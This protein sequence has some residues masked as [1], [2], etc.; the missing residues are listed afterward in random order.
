MKATAVDESEEHTESPRRDGG[1]HFAR[2]IYQQHGTDLL[3]FAQGLTLG[4]VHGA[5]DIVQEAVLRAWRHADRLGSTPGLTRPWL[6]TVVRRL[7]IDAH[8]VRRARP[9]ELIPSALG[10]EVVGDCSDRALTTEVLRKALA[11]LAQPHRDV[12]VHR[13][14]LDL[15]I[16]AT[17]ARLNL[18]TGT[19]KSRSNQALRAL[20]RALTSR[21]ITSAD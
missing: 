7:A 14:C 11:D 10:R 1:Q 12:L 16:E 20:R 5:E 9:A 18:P 13:Y 3:Q 21:G 19:V 15:S 4:D 2:V 8:R 6:F 17:A